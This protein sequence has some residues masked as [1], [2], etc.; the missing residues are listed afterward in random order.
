[1]DN[2]HSSQLP[3]NPPGSQVSWVIRTHGLVFAWTR[4][5]MRSHSHNV[6]RDRVNGIFHG[7]LLQ[8]SVVFLLLLQVTDNENGNNTLTMTVTT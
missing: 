1:M 6:C 3:A 2:E 5:T 7:F 8:P 4:Y